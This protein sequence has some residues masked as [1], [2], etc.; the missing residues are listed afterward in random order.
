Q[1]DVW[2]KKGSVLVTGPLVEGGVAVGRAQHLS[3]RPIDHRIVLENDVAAPPGQPQSAVAPTP[4]AGAVE[5][6]DSLGEEEPGAPAGELG[7]AGPG[8]AGPDDRLADPARGRELDRARD[9]SA[10]VSANASTSA[11]T[12]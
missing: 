9:V 6:N 10:G 2:L 7:T 1:L 4:P 11:S 5:Q 12:S 8:A 3:L